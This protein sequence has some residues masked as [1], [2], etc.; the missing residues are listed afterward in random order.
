MFSRIELLNLVESMTQMEKE[1]ILEFVE[2]LV[3]KYPN[4][5]ETVE[6]GFFIANSENSMVNEMVY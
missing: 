3:K 4:V 1:D 6:F 2:I 5:A